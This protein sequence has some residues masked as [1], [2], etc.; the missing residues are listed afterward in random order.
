MSGLA[1]CG[2]VGILWH[3]EERRGWSEGGEEETVA[4]EEGNLHERDDQQ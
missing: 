3:V 2:A 1:N 4:G